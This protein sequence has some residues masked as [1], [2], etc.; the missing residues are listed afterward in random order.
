MSPS[1]AGR[2]A[3]CGRE[4]R[5][6]VLVRLDGR[7]YCQG[8]CL[9]LAYDLAV[10]TT[11]LEEMVTEDIRKQVRAWARQE[12]EA[13][14]QLGLHELVRRGV[15]RFREA[16]FLEALYELVMPKLL[17][18]EIERS[19]KPTKEEA[20]RG[21]LPPALERRAVLFA[22]RFDIRRWVERL[23]EKRVAVFDMTRGQ[24][25]EVARAREAEG[26]AHL[27]LALLARTLAE[28]L[29]GDERVR[30]RWTVEEIAQLER[31]LA[32]QVRV[33]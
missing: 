1:D 4:R 14:P 8:A 7:F 17:V 19:L 24:L 11:R 28:R 21:A 29:R 33:A 5:L 20:R 9:E 2:C 10:T 27:R 18:L 30:D 22:E 26:N 25:E 13:D 6:W 16:R 12:L 15:E 3:G 23:G 32:E 31:R